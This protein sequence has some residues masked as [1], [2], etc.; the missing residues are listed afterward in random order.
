[1]TEPVDGMYV[2]LCTACQGRL[3]VCFDAEAKMYACCVPCRLFAPMESLEKWY[4]SVYQV[5]SNSKPVA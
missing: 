2:C 4:L 3:V 5:D 1:M